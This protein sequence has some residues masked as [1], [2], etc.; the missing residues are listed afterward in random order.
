MKSKKELKVLNLLQLLKKEKSKSF[1]GSIISN[2]LHQQHF[3]PSL[4]TTAHIWQSKG[5][6]TPASAISK[7]LDVCT[8]KQH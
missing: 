3:L 4:R 1:V 5:D 2:R 6:L 7:D 8:E